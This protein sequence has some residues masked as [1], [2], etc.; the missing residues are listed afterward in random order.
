MADTLLFPL[1]ERHRLA[2]DGNQWIIQRRQGKVGAPKTSWAGIAFLA[3]NKST[4]W[5]LLR[6]EEILIDALA[7]RRMDALPDTF[8][9]F[10]RDHDPE[11]YRRNPAF[12]CA[13]SN[14]R[15]RGLRSRVPEGHC[16]QDD[17]GT[18]SAA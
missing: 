7:I 9:D 6:E 11:A 18:L 15:A 5:R 10:L 14:L 13:Q 1:N 16:A 8:D 12:R 2:Y 17:V 3:H 4:L